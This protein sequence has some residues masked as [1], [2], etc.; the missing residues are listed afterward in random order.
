MPEQS[1][2]PNPEQLAARRRTLVL[3]G[4]RISC[5]LGALTCAAVAL[6]A[7]PQL[8]ISIALGTLLGAVNFVMLARNIAAALDRTVAEVER[9]R[10]QLGSEGPVNPKAV[11]ARPRGA[12]GG[13]RLAFVVL[14]IAFAMT[15]PVTQPMGLAIG[16][17]IV[18]VGTCVAAWREH[19][20][21]LRGGS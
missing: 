7:T 13:L 17:L 14:V 18:L 10:E 21:L 9:T 15:I 2:Q 1:E 3:D 12:G 5:L 20:R 16:V 11:T 19:R 4:V 8:A 6:L